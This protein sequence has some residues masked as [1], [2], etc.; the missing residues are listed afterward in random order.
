MLPNWVLLT[1]NVYGAAQPEILEH[2]ENKRAKVLK[3]M[4]H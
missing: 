2:N 4:E 1:P 3:N